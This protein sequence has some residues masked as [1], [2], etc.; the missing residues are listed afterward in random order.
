MKNQLLVSDGLRALVSIK[1]AKKFVWYELAYQYF[2]AAYTEVSKV[3]T[4]SGTKYDNDLPC[5]FCSLE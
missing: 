2:Q 4:D 5:W 1:C 3:E